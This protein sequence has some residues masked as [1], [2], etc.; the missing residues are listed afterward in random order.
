MIPL[1][2]SPEPMGRIAIDV[3]IPRA[4]NQG[5]GDDSGTYVKGKYDVVS[6][7]GCKKLF[8]HYDR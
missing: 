7:D 8:P 3:A 5:N 1:L 6:L 4:E 2:Q